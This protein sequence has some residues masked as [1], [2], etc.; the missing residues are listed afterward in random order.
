VRGPLAVAIVL[1]AFGGCGRDLLPPGAEE[2][3][4]LDR[5]AE[6]PASPSAGCHPGVFPAVHAERRSLRVASEERSYLLD[7]PAGPADRALPVVV[8]LHGFRSTAW[9]QRWWSGWGILAAAEGFVAVHPEGH[10]DVALLRTTGRGWDFRPGETRDA[11]FI[12]ALLDALEE[13]RCVDRRRVFATGMSNGGFFANLLG[14]V[15]ADRLA[16]VA[17]VAGALALPG[18][19]SA[20]PMPILLVY[21][22]ADRVVPPEMIAGARRWWAA[23][24]GCGAEIERDGCRHY[25]GCELVYC[26]GP[27]A[28]RWPAGAT[29]RIWRFFRGHP[30]P[31]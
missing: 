18:C 24:D 26:E 19:P 5:A 15:L 2:R 17:P 21:G 16:A 25:T 7:A 12:R 13:A 29:A 4:A 22:R 31:S 6:V 1:V 8:S 10:E 11:D 30:R 27:Q 28:H 3:V 9:R 20:A 14:C 23:V